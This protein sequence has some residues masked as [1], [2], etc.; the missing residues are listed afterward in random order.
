MKIKNNNIKLKLRNM[1]EMANKTAKNLKIIIFD[2]RQR[3]T[4]LL[5]KP[6]ILKA[7]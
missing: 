4:S 6:L 7:M 5:H 3:N 2:M 1:E